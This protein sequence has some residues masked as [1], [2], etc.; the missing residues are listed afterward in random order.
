MKLSSIKKSFIT[1]PLAV[2]FLL[3]NIVPLSLV[4]AASINVN[5]TLDSDQTNS[6]QCSLRD[7]VNAAINNVAV[8]GCNA[9]A[10]DDTIFVPQG[11]YKLTLKDSNNNTV[12]LSL[13]STNNNSLTLLGSDAVSTIIDGNGAAGVLQ[14]GNN[15]EDVNSFVTV[16]NLSITKGSNLA[17][18]GGGIHI[19]RATNVNLDTLNI[20]D[21]QAGYGAAIAMLGEW[22]TQ[23]ISIKNSNIYNNSGSG[24][25]V[26]GTYFINSGTQTLEIE[27]TTINDNQASCYGGAGI[28]LESRYQWAGDMIV[29]ANLTNVTVSNNTLVG[30][31]CQSSSF[32]GAIT[33]SSLYSG[34]LRLNVKNSTIANNSVPVGTSSSNL[35]IGMKT[36]TFYNTLITNQS[37]TVPNCRIG[38]S[39]ESLP[40]SKNNLVSDSSC[41]AVMQP[42]S[43]NTV[44]NAPI[45]LEA[46]ANNGGPVKTHAL[47]LKSLAIDHG[48][49]IN[50]A[51]TDA[52]GVKR[53]YNSIC[54]I[55]AYE[56]N[57]S[58]GM[59]LYCFTL[60]KY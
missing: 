40:E 38:A 26:Y 59:S 16:R 43:S 44:T 12:P 27:N 8:K 45:A 9:G 58:S 50:C 29:N 39:Y 17:S 7:A 55:G 42:T 47:P 49:N 18:S 46:L 32:T 36:A 4:Q 6:S 31:N 25:T 19:N 28:Y 60:P 10:G 53:P 37:S 34:N 30:T 51:K 41:N 52:R 15:S 1:V 11:T 20:Y 22:S 13:Y 57:C 5:T 23:K 35:Y 24:F 2:G 33:A 56:Y 3:V 54:D 14:I 48:S 21:N